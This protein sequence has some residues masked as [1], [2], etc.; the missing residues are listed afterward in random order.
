[1]AEIATYDDVMRFLLEFVDYEKVSKF[2]YDISTF[3][4][5]RVEQLMEAVGGPHRKLRAIHVAGT[6]GKG[7]TSII[8][9]S[10]LTAAGYRTGLYTSPHLVRLEERM[11]IDGRMMSEREIVALANRLAPYTERARAEFP[12]ESPTFFELVTAAGFLHFAEQ[13]T[14]LAVV[15]VGMGGRLDATNVITPAVSTITRIDYDHVERL[16]DTLALIAGEK[17]GIIKAGVP[18]VVAQQDAEAMAVIEQRCRE[19]GAPLTRIGQD[20]VAGRV[21]M[22]LTEEGPTT[23]FDLAGP[24]GK[25][26]GLQLHL[27]GAHQVTNAATAIASVAIAARALGLKVSADAIREGCK[28]ARCPARLEYFTGRPPILLDA[29]HNPISMRGVCDTLDRIFAGRRVIV[30]MGVSRDKNSEEMLRQILPR[31]SAVIFTKSDSPRAEEPVALAALARQIS[32]TTAELIPDPRDALS[33]ARQ[34]SDDNSLIV[35]TGSFFLAGNLRP[36]LCTT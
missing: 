1:M 4:L 5:G 34:V 26:E 17:A 24:N 3:S 25:H 13:K 11:T 12:N 14:D 7:S 21:E 30:L 16:G 15:E 35:I 8:S 32:W 10:I 20:Y 31:C 33:R 9:Q 2:K 36:T 18:V 6:K 22:R 29:A 23:C 28:S 27:L 19:R